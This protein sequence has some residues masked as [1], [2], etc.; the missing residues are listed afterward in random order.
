MLMRA[1]V[2]LLAIASQCVAQ[3]ASPQRACKYDVNISRVGPAEVYHDGTTT[4]VENV[5]A[6]KQLIETMG[7]GCTLILS[8]YGDAHGE[9][10]Y[11]H[12]LAELKA[13]CE[14]RGLK[15]WVRSVD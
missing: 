4:K 15:F 9:S 5:A 7:P 10:E 13:L 14:T 2:I 6:L 3:E 12:A 8:P 11:W 1:L